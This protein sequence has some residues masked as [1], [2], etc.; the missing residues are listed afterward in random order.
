MLVRP[1]PFLAL[2]VFASIALVVPAFG[3]TIVV[4]QAAPTTAGTGGYSTILHA[5]ARSY[6]VVI[7]PEELIGLAAGDTITGMTWRRP[8]WTPYADWPA[9]PAMFAAFDVSFS[10]SVNPPGSLSTNYLDNIGPDVVVVREGPLSFDAGVF[11]GGAVSPM[12]NDFGMV[13]PFDT[14]YV[15]TGGDL[16]ITI[17]H[18]GHGGSNGFLDTVGSPFTQAI[19]VSSYTQ[20]TD[21]YAQGLIVTQLT[22]GDPAEPEFRRGDMNADGQLDISDAVGGLGFLFVPGS[23]STCVDAQDVN[24]DGAAD[25]SDV[26]YLLAFLFTPGAPPPADPVGTCGPDPTDDSLGCDDF[27]GCP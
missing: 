22:T 5:Q 23:V 26:V 24:D 4:P 13:I 12:V 16:L 25:I 18:T 6:Q 17:R 19:G 21:W 20:E 15:Y 10:Q 9:A 14:P 27:T 11:P 1:T 8:S 3:Q 2:L 7:G